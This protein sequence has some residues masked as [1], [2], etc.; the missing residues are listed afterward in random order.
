MYLCLLTR[1]YHHH[2]NYY[3]ILSSDVIVS[4]DISLSA[5][6]IIS[7]T[8]PKLLARSLRVGY[9][10]VSTYLSIWLRNCPPLFVSL[11]EFYGVVSKYWREKRRRL[12]HISTNRIAIMTDMYD[13]K[14]IPDF[15]LPPYQHEDHGAEVS[16]VCVVLLIGTSLQVSYCNMRV[17]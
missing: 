13:E 15:N 3:L 8:Y 6:A 4:I 9:T 2:Y 11:N 7:T 10:Q 1:L 14:K 5:A 17:I 12:N 16:F